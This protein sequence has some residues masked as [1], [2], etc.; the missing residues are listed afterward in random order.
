MKMKLNNRY[1]GKSLLL[2]SACSLSML[3]ACTG[4]FMDTN[5]DP[6]AATEKELGYDN[7][8]TGS[9]ITQ[10]QYQMYPCIT[11][12]QNVDVNNYQKMFSLAGDIYSGHQGASNMFDNNGR[13]NTTYDM[14]PDW[15]AAAYTVAY[16]NYM[17]PWYTLYTKKE[18]SPSTFAVGQILKVFGM[19]RI[20]DMYGP[21]PYT[22][23]APASDVAFTSQQAIYNQFFNELDE[24]LGILKAYIKDNPGAKPLANY[25]KI[26]AGDFEK[27]VKFANSL[28][29]RL[30]LRIVYADE[31]TA[32]QK[33]EEAIAGG[34]F[35]DNEDNAMLKVDGAATVN[36]LY[37]I[38]YTYND[39]RL[40]ATMESYLKGYNDPRLDIWFAKSEV[41]GY[42]DYNGIRCGSQF[43]GNDYKVFSNLNVSSSTPIQF[44][45]AAEVY[46]LRAEAALRGWNAGGDAKSLYENGI[47]IAFS[48]PLGA[49]QAK[50]GDASTYIEGTELPQPY[51]DPENR[52]YNYSDVGQVSVNWADA[53]TFDEKLEK[54]ITQKW[55]ALF[56]D[57]QEAWSEF[58]RTGCP[59]VI[60]VAV[61]YSYGV[62]NTVRQIARL[63]YPT[64]LSKD[65][66]SLYQEAVN[67]PELLDGADTGGT[68]LWWD[69]RSDKPY[70]N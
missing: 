69:K 37:M 63:P 45:N 50:A 59:R 9:M 56:P 53:T 22:G 5:T 2:I 31:A 65:Y 67:N 15:C 12:D 62:I 43:T 42:E 58:R 33:A 18:I 34:V 7:L 68:K 64:N 48:Q 14:Y 10:M 32:K 11:K 3:G 29:L 47:T 26:Y 38:C 44:M 40:G 52:S 66:P 6:N 8:G 39:S 19:H 57:G 61:N 28:K 54:I 23:F 13:N 49:T 16:Q 41:S 51:V 70:Q 55:I 35:M 4:D 30:A 24:S 46:F 36:P 27:W 21:I 25:D 1:F 20:T 60:Q 17:S